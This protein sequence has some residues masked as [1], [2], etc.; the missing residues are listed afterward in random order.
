MNNKEDNHPKP[1]VI[2]AFRAVVVSIE[3]ATDYDE[4]FY[5]GLLELVKK[6]LIDSV[7]E[8]KSGY[9]CSEYWF[10]KFPGMMRALA[11]NMD[12]P[13]TLKR[14]ICTAVDEYNERFRQVSGMHSTENCFQPDNAFT[15]QKSI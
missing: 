5:L 9:E 13:T 7:E 15:Q 6:T 1:Q 8:L 11:D 2:A 4:S 10:L 12:F 3:E 14:S